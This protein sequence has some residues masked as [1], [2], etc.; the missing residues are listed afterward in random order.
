MPTLDQIHDGIAKQV[1]RIEEL[2]EE[3]AT[4]GDQAARAEADYRVIAAQERLKAAAEPGEKRTVSEI[5]A[6]VTVETQDELLRHLIAANRLTVAR[7]ALRAAQARL[8]GLR[9]L[10]TSFRSAGG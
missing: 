2:V 1:R 9:T 10:A 6:L 3:I 8:D 7:E 4:A 5:D